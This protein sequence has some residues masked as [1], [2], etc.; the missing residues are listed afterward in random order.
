MQDYLKHGTSLVSKGK[1][2]PV[3][4]APSSPSFPPSVSSASS[5]GS[6]HPFP[7]LVI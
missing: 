7:Q 1:K 2:K 5:L 6:H 4:I 3:S